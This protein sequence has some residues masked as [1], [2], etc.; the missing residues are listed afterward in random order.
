MKCSSSVVVVLSI[1][2][3]TLEIA[4]PT[5]LLEEVVSSFISTD[6]IRKFFMLDNIIEPT[7]AS[8][9][10]DEDVDMT[11]FRD[12]CDPSL[13][14]VF[15]KTSYQDVSPVEHVTG[16]DDIDAA[17]RDIKRACSRPTR[18]FYWSFNKLTFLSNCSRLCFTKAVV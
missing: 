18:E 17:I 6:S 13:S 9:S 15:E 8:D 3:L 2:K 10:S 14:G 7:M 11:C 1:L 5:L 12:V 16:D 4:V